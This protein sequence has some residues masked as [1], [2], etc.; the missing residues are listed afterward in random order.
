MGAHVGGKLICICIYIYIYFYSYSY[1]CIYIYIYIYIHYYI[2][3]IYT[4]YVIYFIAHIYILYLRMGSY[5]ILIYT[6]IHWLVLKIHGDG[7]N[8]YST[9]F[10][11]GMNIRCQG[12]DPIP[13]SRSSVLL[14]SN[15]NQLDTHPNSALDP[16]QENQHFPKTKTSSLFIFLHVCPQWR[17][18]EISRSPAAA[19]EE[20]PWSFCAACRAQLSVFCSRRPLAFPRC[21]QLLMGIIRG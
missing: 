18:P 19:C 7:S 20:L 17:S 3:Y 2:I 1:N 8:T 5:H 21:G 9:I 15:Q 13:I 11:G 14:T 16:E 4:L 10:E 6:T 12:F